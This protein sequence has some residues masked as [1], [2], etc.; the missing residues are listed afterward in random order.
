MLKNKT[1]TSIVVYFLIYWLTFGQL[2]AAN[3]D[4]PT[5]GVVAAG[6]AEINSTATKM[7]INQSTDQVIINWNTF[8]IGKDAHVQFIQPSVDSSA[9]NRVLSVGASNIFGQLTSNGNVFLINPNGIL[10]GPSS[11]VDVGSLIATTANISDSNFLNKNYTFTAERLS[12]L[13]N[14]GQI[15]GGSIALIGPSIRNEGYLIATL[16]DVVLASSDKVSLSFGSNQKISVAIDPSKLGSQ[17]QHTGSI[18]ATK[19]SV[20][21]RADAAQTLVDQTINGPSSANAIV[22]N[23][24]VVRLVSSSGSIKANS[25]SLDSGIRG[26]SYVNGSIDVSQNNGKGGNINILGQEV[27]VGNLSKL[28]ATGAIGGGNI[29]VGGDWQGGNGVAQS[30]YTSVESGAILDVSAIDN[31]NGGKIVAWSDIKDPNSKTITRGTFLA[32]GG[33]NGGNGG[34]IETSGS[35]IDFEGIQVDTKAPKGNLGLWLIDP[36]NYTIGS[37]QATSIGS[38][39]ASSNVEITTSSDV[40]AYGSSGSNSDT[41]NIT[42]N[43]DITGSLGSLTLTAAGTI[44]LNANISTAGSQTFNSN[45]IVSAASAQ[46]NSTNN[47]SAGGDIIFAGTINGSS[48][49]ANSLF[50]L[51]GAGT[52]SVAGNIGSTTALSYLGLGGTGT[53]VPGSTQ[54]FSYTGAS[55][56][57]TASVS[58]SYTFQTWGAQGGDITSHYPVIGAK[59]GYALGN[60]TLT[61]GQTISIYVGGEGADRAGNHPDPWQTYIAGGWN[62]GGATTSAGNSTPGGGAT[63]IRIGGEALTNRVIVAG[64]GGGGGWYYAAGGAGGGLS[65]IN[66]TVDAGWSSGGT[67]GG[68]GSQSLGGAAGVLPN[69]GPGKTTAGTLGL[70]GNGSGNSAGGGGGGGGYYGGGGGGYG[71]GG[72]G[73]SSYIGGVTSGSTIAGNASMTNPAGGTMTGN[74]GNGYARIS[75]P[76]SVAFTAGTQTGTITLSGAVVSGTTRVNTSGTASIAGV[77]SGTGALIKEGSGSLTLSNANTYSGNTT[78][79]AGTLAVTGSLGTSRSYA[80]NISNSG[81]LTYNS[82]LNQTLGGIVSGTGSLSKLGTG[83]LTLSGANSYSGDTLINAGTLTV[84]GSLANTSAVNI[85]SGATYNLGASD[86]VGSI[87]GAGN[88]MLNN[89]TLS[90][91]GDNTSTNFSGVISGAG[92]LTKSGNGTL[93]LSGA[94]EYTGGTTVAS[95]GSLKLANASALSSSSSVTVSSGG[96][97]DVNGYSLSNTLSLSGTGVNSV[98]ALYNSSTSGITIGGIITL[99][100]TASITS[101]GDVIFNNAIRGVNGQNYSLT[102]TATGKTITLNGLIGADPTTYRAGSSGANPYALNISAGLIKINNDITTN[103]NQTYTGAVEIGDNGSNGTTRT[104]LSLNPNVTFTNTVDDLV[105]NTHTLDVRAIAVA[106]SAAETPQ[107]NFLGDVGGTKALYAVNAIAM[108]DPS[109]S[110]AYGNVPGTYN[111]SANYTGS[112][113]IGGKFNTELDQNFVGKDFNFGTNQPFSNNGNVNFYVYQSAGVGPTLSITKINLGNRAKGVFGIDSSYAN[114]INTNVGSSTT[115]TQIPIKVLAK[116]DNRKDDTIKGLKA[117]LV[118]Q[119]GEEGQVYVGNIRMKADTNKNNSNEAKDCSKTQKSE[120]IMTASLECN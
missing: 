65:G 117:G 75:I 69:A 31:G 50:I 64:G 49:N 76:E 89:Y 2:F 62:G 113:R 115:S 54:N 13:V 1:S 86:T 27:Y 72:G 84:S 92:A 12:E 116:N 35:S 118:H 106:G 33:A 111:T 73:G 57:F 99:G 66:G 43:S 55:Q 28:N 63:D 21:I 93:T 34:N 36:Y 26:Q 20:I 56:T 16:G 120:K 104:L 60:Y 82:S 85:L 22:S 5:N 80:G 37:S 74:S 7:T 105:R 67:G 14:Q 15:K 87:T 114:Y 18:S 107:I 71:E 91:G 81:V 78:I 29:L 95:G 103:Q 97:L 70:G 3:L 9:L 51:S 59:G 45:V 42:I 83:T 53:Y 39:L 25:V 108:Y 6:A 23:N 77:I 41:G 40:T 11:S 101:L 96:T 68:G 48:A 94:N 24:G 46:L 52:I 4:L 38:A 119:A 8:N 44:Y 10:F 109:P 61:A 110:V 100:A 98:G 19:G 30:I 32:R 90:S 88:I 102:M 17:I 58:G 79:N 112:I 47:S